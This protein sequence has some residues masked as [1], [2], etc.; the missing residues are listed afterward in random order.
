LE[1]VV[2]DDQIV[3]ER[4]NS[5]SSSANEFVSTGREYHRTLVCW[6]GRRLRRMFPRMRVRALCRSVFDPSVEPHLAAA[7]VIFGAV[8]A[9]E[10]R[11]FLNRVLLQQLV[12]YFDAGVLVSRDDA[13]LDFRTRADR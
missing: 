2:A 8:D 10:P 7:D 1:V 4:G 11:H 3:F 5:D 13:G 12:P 6:F 9:D